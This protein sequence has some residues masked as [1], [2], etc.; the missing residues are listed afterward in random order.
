VVGLRLDSE[1]EDSCCVTI[2]LGEAAAGMEAQLREEF[3]G[4]ARRAV[5]KG[6]RPDYIRFAPIPR[7]FKGE[8]L[9]PQLKQEFLRS[10]GK[11]A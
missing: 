3:A 4:E 8:I 7:S 6:A 10:L 1:H 11:A 5:S 2:E 9:Y